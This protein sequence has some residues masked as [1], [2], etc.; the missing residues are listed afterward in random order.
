[1]TLKQ[2][3]FP[4]TIDTS[5]ADIIADFFV[6]ALSASVRYDRGVGYFSAGWLKLTARGMVTFAGNG[7]HARWV[8]SPI[9]AEDDWLALQQGTAARHDLALRTALER[10]IAELEKTLEKDTL[11]A[12]AWMV[13]DEILDF[14]LALPRNKL[15]GGEFHDKFGIFTDGDGQRVSFSGSYNE[16]IQGTRNY[17]SLRI[18]SSWDPAYSPIVHSEHERFERLWNNLDPNVQVYTLPDAARASILKLRSEPRPYLL[19]NRSILTL[20]VME[21]RV[22]PELALRDYQLQAIEAWFTNGSRGILEMATGTGKTKTSLSAMARLYE[23]ER[24]L[25]LIISV[26]YQHLVD[27][28]FEDAKAFGLQP[29]LAYKRK[30]D[31]LNKLHQQ[32]LEYNRNDRKI[33]SVI[34]T[35]TTFIDS[36]FRNIISGLQGPCLLIADEVHH[37]GAARSRAALPE[38]ISARLGLSA[39]PDRWYDEGGTLALRGYFG[40]TVFRLDLSDAIKR[41]I[42][43][44]YIYY[45]QVVE[46]TLDE[47]VE[48]Q[49]ISEQISKLTGILSIKIRPPQAQESNAPILDQENLITETKSFQKINKFTQFGTPDSSSL[50]SYS[51]DLKSNPIWDSIALLPTAKELIVSVGQDTYELFRS[52]DPQKKLRL[53]QTATQILELTVRCLPRELCNE[54]PIS[55]ETYFDPSNTR[56]HRAQ[57]SA[58]RTLQAA[59]SQGHP[60]LTTTKEHLL[61][62]LQ[63]HNEKIQLLSLTLLLE[64]QLDKN[65]AQRILDSA[66]YFTG[67]SQAKF[68]ALIEN[69]KIIKI[70]GR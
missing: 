51:H 47:M 5:S 34:T 23:Q 43:V 53:I 62:A 21:P 16:S 7:G 35:H 64:A 40:D 29:I 18:F 12:L 56:F 50:E 8:T 1:M 13:A 22:P 60:I 70:L 66:L 3:T 36:D 39:T 10:N 32:V 27:Q 68:F 9:L 42:L 4:I 52:S 48:Y 63:T 45:P 33:I 49:E 28:W 57:L 19:S 58:I 6:P 55:D 31:W 61:L 44:P 11:S 14:R 17:E 38:N 26:P 2:L 20:T 59:L 24:R 37:L 46:L 41:G 25:A 54:Q 69:S 30:A 67:Q 65:D 15:Q